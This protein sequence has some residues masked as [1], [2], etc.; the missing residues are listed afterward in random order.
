MERV[1]KRYLM[2]NQGDSEDPKQNDFD[3]IKQ[4]LQQIKYE[5]V[6][7]M[8]KSREESLRNAYI[9]NNGIQFIAEELLDQKK[10]DLNLNKS[11][12]NNSNNASPNSSPLNSSNHERRSN[13]ITRFREL[14]NANKNLFK[15]AA[16]MNNIDQIDKPSNN[17]NSLNNMNYLDKKIN[18]DDQPAAGNQKKIDSNVTALIVNKQ[19]NSQSQNQSESTI[20]SI[21]NKN[22]SIEEFYQNRLAYDFQTLYNEDD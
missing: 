19:N 9:I 18:L 22:Q 12:Q 1:V 7:D 20:S 16:A 5:I 13:S 2:H 10:P 6:N 11:T 3:E 17:V 4:D 15:S 8:K 14:V 21:F